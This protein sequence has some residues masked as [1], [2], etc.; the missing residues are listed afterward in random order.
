MSTRT[1]G[2]S[3]GPR[4]TL[5]PPGGGGAAILGSSSW[6][7]CPVVKGAF[8]WGLAVRHV[9]SDRLRPWPETSVCPQTYGPFPGPS[10]GT[11]LSQ[12]S[13]R[14]ALCREGLPAL[15]R[16]LGLR[17][18]TV[19]AALRAGQV[20]PPLPQ[21]PP[22]SSPSC[23][24]LPWAPPGPPGVAAGTGL[25][26]GCRLHTGCPSCGGTAGQA[27]AVA[28]ARP[29]ELRGSG[30]GAV[31]SGAPGASWDTGRPRRAEPEALLGLGVWP[32]VSGGFSFGDKFGIRVSRKK[33]FKTEKAAAPTTGPDC[34]PV[35][36]AGDGEA[37]PQ[38]PSGTPRESQAEPTGSRLSPGLSP[39]LGRWGS[40]QSG[41]GGSGTVR[42]G[43]LGH[44]QALEPSGGG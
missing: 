28:E 32:R 24:P 18:G 37:G 43:G 39:G 3:Q 1:D 16:A 2:S 22:G 15:P 19:C 36:L 20:S 7:E 12:A 42:L 4:P 29:G 25:Q 34:W 13:C 21:G 11:L 26:W 31:G 38:G 30:G 14:G 5:P 41:G 17:P 44:T 35:L 40:R 23:T 8:P 6:A 9:F 27:A 10:R 33:K